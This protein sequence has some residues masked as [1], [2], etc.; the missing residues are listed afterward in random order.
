MYDSFMKLILI[1]FRMNAFIL[2]MCC[3]QVYLAMEAGY[4]EKVDELCER[5]FLEGYV[6]SLGKLTPMILPIQH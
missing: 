4:M 2:L 1:Y 3:A 6:N 5:Y